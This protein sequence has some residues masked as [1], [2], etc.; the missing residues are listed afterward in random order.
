LP[1]FRLAVGPADVGHLLG[2][3]RAAHFGAG[4]VPDV[5]W[6]DGTLLDRRRSD[7]RRARG[8][9]PHP[10]RRHQPADHQILRRLLEHAASAGV[11]AAHG[12][13][14]PRSRVPA[15]AAAD[16][17]RVSA[18]VRDAASRRHAQ[19]DP[20]AARAHHAIDAGG[21]ARMSLGPYADFIV[22][23]YAVAVFVIAALVAWVVLDHLAQRRLIADLEA[24][25]IAR[26]SDRTAREP[27]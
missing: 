9:D 2:L 1:G 16:G 4:A 7:A 23:S 21:G 6:R 26:R 3:G 17:A 5:S 19:R 15:S 10:R 14:D 8:C 13:I 22:A 20:A 25:G 18:P 24:R 27:A 11:G 12:R